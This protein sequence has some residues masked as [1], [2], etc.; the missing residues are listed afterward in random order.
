VSSCDLPSCYS[1]GFTSREA[2]T[3]LFK[4]SIYAQIFKMS[5][6]EIEIMSPVGSFES[7]MAAIQGANR[8]FFA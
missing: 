6:Q 2:L 3:V 7:L 8:L 4:S 5:F 1:Q